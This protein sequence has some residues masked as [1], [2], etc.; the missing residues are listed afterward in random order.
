V[1]QHNGYIVVSSEPGKGTTVDTYL[2][3]PDRPFAQE[4]ATVEEASGGSET[5]LLVED[6]PAVRNLLGTIL[7]RGGY[8]VIGAI[9]GD[10]ALRVYEKH[11]TRIDLVVLDVVMPGRN[12]REVL[13]E[14]ARTDPR[15]RALFMSGYTGDVV[16][17][18]GIHTE[19]VDFLQKPLT[20]NGLLSK[21]REVLDR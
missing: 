3:L 16:V 9:D 6:D 13:E 8:T 4:P 18:K 17:G 12:G 20:V 10:D 1:K 7:E 11:G 15:A 14:I 5:I 21:V 2:P 19:T